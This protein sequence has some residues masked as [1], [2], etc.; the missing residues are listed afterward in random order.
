[1]V[2]ILGRSATSFSMGARSLR[3]IESLDR[4]GHSWGRRDFGTEIA[5]LRPAHFQ[6]G[7]AELRNARSHA[8][9]VFYAF[10]SAANLFHHSGKSPFWKT[11]AKSPDEWLLDE[12]KPGRTALFVHRRVDDPQFP[13]RM[14]AG[15][16]GGGGRWLL[17]LTSKTG[18]DLWEASWKVGDQNAPDRC[19]WRVSY[20]LVA[21]NTE[22][23]M[24]KLRNDGNIREAVFARG[25]EVRR[26][27]SNSCRLG[28][29]GTGRG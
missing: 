11:V 2:K 7:R 13:D 5:A 26:R 27:M 22:F 15:F 20:G 4:T 9:P 18:M 1:M 14:S 23:S 6:I 29:V 10:S 24:P 17:A 12:A 19:I 28:C 8:G 3:T 21:E 25:A 16:V